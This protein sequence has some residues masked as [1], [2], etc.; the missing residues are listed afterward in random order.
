MLNDFLDQILIFR[1]STLGG[2][3]FLASCSQH[4]FFFFFQVYGEMERG[5]EKRAGWKTAGEG[6]KKRKEKE[7][8]FNLST[9]TAPC[10]FQQNGLCA[11]YFSFSQG[12]AFVH[13]AVRVA[14]SQQTLIALRP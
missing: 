10:W 5:Q 2:P 7:N 1:M 3:F 12:P 6:K 11:E 14:G 8:A 13:R 4:I 9:I